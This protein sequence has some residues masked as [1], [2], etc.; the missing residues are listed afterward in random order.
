MATTKHTADNTAWVSTGIAG[1][2]HVTMGFGQG[3]ISFG[4]VDP[5]D[6][7]APSHPL[8]TH[9]SN[10]YYKGTDILWIRASVGRITANVSV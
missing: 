5:V 1:P 9:H 10:F 4:G 3:L 2:L 7:N 8:H 6:P